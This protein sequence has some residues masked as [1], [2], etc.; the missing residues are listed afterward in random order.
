ML[1]GPTQ[2]PLVGLSVDCDEMFADL[3]ENADRPGASTDVCAGPTFGGDGA[4]E[5]QLVAIQLAPSVL[6][7]QA[8]RVVG[9]EVND[10]LDREAG[11]TGPNEG[12]V[13]LLYTSRC[14]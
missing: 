1:I 10:A 3:G 9:G 11:A 5:D 8:G 7:P 6:G 4:D 14:V 2:P 13:C 12:G